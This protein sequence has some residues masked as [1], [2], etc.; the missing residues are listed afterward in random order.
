MNYNDNRSL[1]GIITG[2][3]RSGTT[4]LHNLINSHSQI[5]SGFECGILLGT[6]KNFEQ[7]EPFGIWMR[8]NRY[9]FGLERNK[10]LDDIKDMTY[11]EVYQYIGKNKGSHDGHFQSIMRKSKY[12]IDKTPRYIYE[13]E[14]VIKKIDLHLSKKVVTKYSLLKNYCPA[15]EYHQ[16]YLEKR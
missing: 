9:H 8:Q 5:T 4:V 6:L 12:F 14:S 11:N 1:I 16:R 3:E 15:E 7:N 2:M 10:Y 13:L